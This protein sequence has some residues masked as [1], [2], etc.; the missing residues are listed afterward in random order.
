MINSFVDYK[1]KSLNDLYIKPLEQILEMPL[2]KRNIRWFE[3]V[4]T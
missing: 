1:E 2:E 3:L 4:K